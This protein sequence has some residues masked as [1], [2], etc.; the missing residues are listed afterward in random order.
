MKYVYLTLNWVFGVFFGI[1]GFV[2]LIESPLGGLCLIAISILLLPPI[3]NAIY[4]KT[5]KE[6]HVKARAILIFVL[7]IAFGTFVGQSQDKK[8]AEIAAKKAKEQSEQTAKARQENIDYFNQNREQII[9]T[10]STALSEKKYQS[11]I[12]QSSRYVVANDDELNDL[13]NQAKKALDEIKRAEKEAREKA[14]RE[15]KT[16][17]ILAKLKRVPVSKYEEN[18]ELYQQLVKLNPDNVSY[19]GRLEHYSKKLKEQIEKERQEQEKIKKERKIRIAK[20]GE[21]PTQ[22]AWDGSYFAVEQYLERVANDP[23]SIEID[24]CTKV[25][26]TNEGWLVGCD[27]RGRNAFGGMIRQSNWFTIVHGRVIQIHEASAYRP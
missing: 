3:R 17:E 10:I 5:N 27:Y 19:Q 21:P 6:L 26:H 20:F 12:S 15:T 18:K 11:I 24:G 4:L 2:S 22:S 8:A 23:D 1:T 14:Q 25:Y 7:F 16:E 9:S 13:R